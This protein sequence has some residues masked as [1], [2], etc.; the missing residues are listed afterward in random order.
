M[1]TGGS[2]MSLRL[3]TIAPVPGTKNNKS[4]EKKVATPLV[5]KVLRLTKPPS[6]CEL[7]CLPPL[8]HSL[9]CLPAMTIYPSHPIPILVH[10]YLTPIAYRE[11]RKHPSKG[12]ISLLQRHTPGAY[13]QVD[14]IEIKS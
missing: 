3:G 13:L 4:G 7:L 5:T 2:Y 10:A 14:G 9:T 12:Q 6:I 8:T 1:A 11:L